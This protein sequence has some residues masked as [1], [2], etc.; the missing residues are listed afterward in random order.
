[1]N[2]ADKTEKCVLS[3]AEAERGSSVLS[4]ICMRV[5]TSL[6]V[7]QVSVASQSITPNLMGK[8]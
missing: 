2:N 5:R 7:G 4:N 1:M 8:A 6:T 3:K